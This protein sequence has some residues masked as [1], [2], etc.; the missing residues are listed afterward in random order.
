MPSTR[1]QAAKALA[2]DEEPASSASFEP[3]SRLPPDVR[4]EVWRAACSQPTFMPGVCHF[5]ETDHAAAREPTLVVHE[6]RNAD[7][8]GTNTEAHDMALLSDTP[9]RAYDPARDIL[10]VTHEAYYCFTGQCHRKGPKWVTKIRHLAIGLRSADQSLYL[11]IAMQRLAS[12][13]T[14]SVVYPGPS[15]TFDWKTAVEP[16]ADKSTPLRRL[17]E[18]EMG[19][20]TITADYMYNTW[21]GDYPIQW[22]NKIPEHMQMVK[23]N[24]DDNCSP[25]SAGDLWPTPLWDDEAKQVRIRYEARC[26]E[27][28]P[29]PKKFHS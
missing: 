4:Q 22:T 15:G 8:L 2:K 28:L 10:Y 11:P 3:F 6:P 29:T 14:L 27:A 23:Q 18:E 19:A 5:T 7:V 1:L 17:T 26:F 21:A 12:L 24:L 9:A 13:E 25:R 20:V 16:P